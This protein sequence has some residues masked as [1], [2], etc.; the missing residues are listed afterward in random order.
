MP[1][2]KPNEALLSQK[3][4]QKSFGLVVDEIKIEKSIRNLVSIVQKIERMEPWSKRAKI[5]RKEINRQHQQLE[6]IR[7]RNSAPTDR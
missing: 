3:R 1:P 5:I 4:R 6:K 7:E 2:E